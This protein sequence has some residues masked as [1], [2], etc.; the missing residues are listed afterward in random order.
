M[1]LIGES[2]S[3]KILV[4]TFVGSHHLGFYRDCRASEIRLRSSLEKFNTELITFTL[5][6]LTKLVPL[7]SSSRFFFFTRYGVG[8]WFWKPILIKHALNLYNP[9]YLIYVDSDCGFNAR[10]SDFLDLALKDS[11]IAFFVQNNPLNGWISKRAVRILGLTDEQLSNSQ[12]VTAG[13]VML[14]NTIKAREILTIWE[15]T[16]KNPRLLLHPIINFNGRKHRHDQSI[17]SALI[18]RKDIFCNLAG[19][20][21]YSLGIESISDSLENSWIFSGD[22]SAS[23]S[24][25]SITGRL[26]S[27]SDYYSRWLYDLAK[28]FFIS[29]IHWLYFC[30]ERGLICLTNKKILKSPPSS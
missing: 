22:I 8:A 14:K 9:D 2:D 23:P 3:P 6:D 11:D 4:I 12:L 20:G 1:T 15:L 25:M 5:G 29:P 26:R 21:F 27:I 24:S 30:V 16:M 28:S 17:L 18:A 7:F 13:I 19:T 10:P